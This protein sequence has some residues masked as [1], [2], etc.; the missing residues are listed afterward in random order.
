MSFR[1]KVI[2]DRSAVLFAHLGMYRNGELTM[3]QRPAVIS[4]GATVE[5]RAAVLPGYT[6]EAGGVLSAGN[7]GMPAKL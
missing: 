4:S 2:I 3:L 1:D 7:L 6:L 5:A